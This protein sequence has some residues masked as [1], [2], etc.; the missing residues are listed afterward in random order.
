MP[1]KKRNMSKLI[2]PTNLGGTQDKERLI[3]PNNLKN[4]QKTNSGF[5]SLL[6]F[7]KRKKLR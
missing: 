5:K 7:T 2:S 4:I 1:N 3:K 6:K